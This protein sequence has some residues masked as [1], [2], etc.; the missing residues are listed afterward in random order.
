M[1]VNTIIGIV[2]ILLGSLVTLM[3]EKIAYSVMAIFRK[4]N[5]EAHQDVDELAKVKEELENGERATEE[6][7]R[8]KLAEKRQREL[9]SE[10]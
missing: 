5:P 6:V 4:N 1:Q 7:V 3:G 8:Q 2:V 10:D 9:P